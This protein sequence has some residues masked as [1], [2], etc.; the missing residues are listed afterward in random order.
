[1]PIYSGEHS[2]TFGE[3]NTWEDWHLIPSSRP[4][5]SPP[6]PNIRLLNIPGKS[7]SLD[8]TDVFGPVVYADRTGSFEFYVDHETKFPNDYKDE[9]KAGKTWASWV[10]CY[11]EVL[12]YIHGSKLQAILSDDPDYYYEGRFSINEWR[13]NPNFSTIVINYTVQ[14]YK[15]AVAE[16]G[17]T[18][19]WDKTDFTDS[20]KTRLTST[21]NV[22][23]AEGGPNGLSFEIEGH[24]YRTIPTIICTESGVQFY[25]DDNNPI[26]LKEG[27]NRPSI[28]VISEGLHTLRFIGNGRISLHYR[29]GAL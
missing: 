15:Y 17:D 24:G 28:A 9:K 27:T 29:G 12:E 22:A 2:I 20:T 23:L 18:W 14:P 25:F 3:K 1:M 5:F 26:E 16:F 21:I 11:Q 10:E 7:G 6:Q 8:V 13:S 4:V 19:L